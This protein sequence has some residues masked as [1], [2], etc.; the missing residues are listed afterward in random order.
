MSIAKYITGCLAVAVLLVSCD[1]KESFDVK[2]DPDIKI[3]LNNT[4]PGDAPANSVFYSLVNIP[5]VAGSGWANL[6]STFPSVIKFPVYATKPVNGDVTVTAELDNSLIA[7][8][9]AANNTSYVEFPAGLLNTAG[10]TARLMSGT[11]TSAD[12]ITIATNLTLLGTLT[13]KAYMAPIKLTTLS[14]TAAGYVSTTS[15]VTY[16]VAKVDFR[17]IKFNA[18]AADALGTLI[19]P[20]SSWVVNLNPVALTIGGSGSITDGSTSSWSRFGVSP[21]TV[22]IDMQDSKNVTGIRLNTTTSTTYN[23]LQVE[24]SLSNDGIN[25]DFIGAPLKANLTFTS[26]NHYILFYKA[27]PARYV[28]L[29]VYYTNNANNN[30]YRIAEVD[31][32]AN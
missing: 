26:G 18:P 9:N 3:F 29:K 30:N 23:P 32:Y 24:V 21:V 19:T 13:D 20:K 4:G 8:Y 22:D 31:V 15:Q 2:G 1:K 6:S 11:T 16:I 12:S 14:N 27:I 7:A 17:R 10:L 25:Y 28:R 5:D